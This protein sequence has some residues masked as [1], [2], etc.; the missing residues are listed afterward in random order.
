MEALKKRDRSA[1]RMLIVVLG[2]LTVAWFG[3]TYVLGMF[4]I[5]SA[6]MENT[7]HINDRVLVN[8]IAKF[9][10]PIKHGDIIVFHDPGSWLDKQETSTG[11]T[12]VKRVIG[13]AGDTVSCVGSG[14]PIMVNNVVVSEPYIKKGENP[15]NDSFSVVVP[16]GTVFV[17][18][19]NRSNSNDSR[20][21]ATQFVPLD[22]VVGAVFFVM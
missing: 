6:S 3:A 5:P 8:R 2:A 14:Q 1:V 4:Y 17:M 21:Q 9:Y 10:T 15:S 18:G 12:L 16:E 19:D 22:N 11:D 13:V 20:Y 7:L